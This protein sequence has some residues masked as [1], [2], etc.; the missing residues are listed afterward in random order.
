MSIINEV[1]L[2]G[3]GLDDSSPVVGNNREIMVEAGTSAG[4][5]AA[6]LK[7]HSLKLYHVLES[8]PQ[9]Y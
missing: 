4:G 1:C 9:E 8:P 3:I 2:S 5:H 7:Q 6:F